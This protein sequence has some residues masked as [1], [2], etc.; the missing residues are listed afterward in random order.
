VNRSRTYVIAVVDGRVVGA[1]DATT[2][3]RTGTVSKLRVEAD[4]VVN[5]VLDSSS[6][7]EVPGWPSGDGDA[8]GRKFLAM[9]SLNSQLEVEGNTEGLPCR[10]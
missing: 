1:G 5:A 2:V 9:V 3:S 4:Q 8:G 10:A 6:L 7:G